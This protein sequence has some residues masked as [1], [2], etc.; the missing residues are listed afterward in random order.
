MK[1][2]ILFLCF[3]F[4]HQC[5]SLSTIDTITVYAVDVFNANMIHS[6]QRIAKDLSS[7]SIPLRMELQNYLN[8]TL[9]Q[10]IVSELRSKFRG[11]IQQGLEK[12][13]DRDDCTDKEAIAEEI[14][15]RIKRIG[16]IDVN[17]QL[18]KWKLK[19]LDYF[20]INKYVFFEFDC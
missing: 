14:I 1:R 6:N 20:E 18:T 8:E 10:H 11:I 4:I 12:K 7:N 2:F 3:T 17:S 13:C 5:V 16:L 15:G 9:T 19:H